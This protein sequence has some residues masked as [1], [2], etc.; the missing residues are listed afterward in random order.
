MEYVVTRT[1]AATQ[2]LVG[3]GQWGAAGVTPV[4][5]QPVAAT[6]TLSG[7]IDIRCRATDETSGGTIGK[8]LLVETIR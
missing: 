5:L 8:M 1:G 7:A 4:I 2:T 3:V 6:E